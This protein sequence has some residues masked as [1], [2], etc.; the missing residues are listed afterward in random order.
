MLASM[1]RS[2]FNWTVCSVAMEIDQL[3]VRNLNKERLSH[4]NLVIWK[5]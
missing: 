3:S 2:L 4:D 5:L 1:S